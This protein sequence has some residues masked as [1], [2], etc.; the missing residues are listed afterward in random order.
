VP[1]AA[2]SFA[3]LPRAEPF[4]L[5]ATGEGFELDAI[6]IELACVGGLLPSAVAWEIERAAASYAD[7]ATAERHLLTAYRSAPEHAAVHIALYRFY[8]YKN[9]LREA[10]GIGERCLA[11]AAR[12]NGLSVDWRAVSPQDADF[13][14][15][16]ILPR[17]YLFTLKACAYLHLRLGELAEGEAMVGKLIELDPADRLGGSVLRGVLTRMGPDDDD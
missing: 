14:S 9:R 6:A 8:F 4:P 12:D 10:L 5:S 2:T 16:A 1:N 17:F 13:A 7:D 11:K 15:Y 3:E